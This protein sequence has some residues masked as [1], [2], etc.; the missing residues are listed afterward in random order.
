MSLDEALAVADRRYEKIYALI[1]RTMT[2]IVESRDRMERAK[3][4][5]ASTRESLALLQRVFLSGGRLQAFSALR[6]LTARSAASAMFRGSSTI[7]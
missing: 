3:S 2:R 7:R 6:E 5:A 4:L 1:S